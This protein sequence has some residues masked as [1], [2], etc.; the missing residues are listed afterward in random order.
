MIEV[1]HQNGTSCVWARAMSDMASRKAFDGLLDQGAHLRL[2][3]IGEGG[4]PADLVHQQGDAF[5][6]GGDGGAF[7]FGQ[8]N[9]GKT[10]PAPNAS[11]S[12]GRAS[13][14][15]RPMAGAVVD[16]TGSRQPKPR[17][18][19]RQTAQSVP[20]GCQRRRRSSAA[21]GAE[22]FM[23]HA[24]L[25]SGPATAFTAAWMARLLKPKVISAEAR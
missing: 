10:L 22:D 6:G 25:R 1:Q 5:H 21:M 24:A 11:R 15:T 13:S 3:Q 7:F 20:R 16:R 12:P 19:C 4:L 14:R 8:I 23:G 2:G 18:G 9:H 17:V